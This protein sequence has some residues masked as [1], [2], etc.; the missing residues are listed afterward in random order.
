MQAIT[1][2]W[3]IWLDRHWRFS[4]FLLGLLIFLLLA[5]VFGALLGLFNLPVDIPIRQTSL[6]L[7]LFFA[8]LNATALTGTMAI[9]RR[10]ELAL[11]QL[12][13]ILRIDDERFRYLRASLSGTTAKRS[14]TITL[15]SLAIG[16]AHSAI[17]SSGDPNQSYDLQFFGAN[18]GGILSWF[19]MLH[20]ITALVWNAHMFAKLGRDDMEIDALRPELLL[21]FAT[22]ALLP[23]LTLMATQLFYPLLS[24]NGQFSPIATL[25]GFIM[26]LL[27]ALY[28]LLRTTWPVHMRMREAKASLLASSEGSIARWRETNPDWNFSSDAMGELL[29]ILAFRNHV[30]ALPVWPFNLGLLGRWLFYVVIPPLTWVM[31]ALM[32]NLIDILV[33]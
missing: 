14:W 33:V 16:I 8:G 12:K 11:D 1:L 15:I 22:V 20:L 17:L 3:F 19:I 2:Y 13:P 28:L 9:I 24:L 32:E 31:A 5:I 18:L 23:S 27:S 4:R 29:P 10:S 21:P 26:T 25:P 7:C 6:G 30:R